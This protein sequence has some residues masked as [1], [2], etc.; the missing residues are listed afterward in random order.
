MKAK[1]SLRASGSV[2][3]TAVPL[4]STP[5]PSPCTRGSSAIAAHR[6]DRRSGGAQ[7]FDGSLRRTRRRPLDLPPLRA[8]D[9]AAI[10][11]ETAAGGPPTQVV[12][13]FAGGAGDR[14]H[15]LGGLGERHVQQCGELAAGADRCLNDTFQELATRPNLR[16]Y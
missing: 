12:D 14:H 7:L 6:F 4:I 13:R 11:V 1:S 15:V 10:G 5:C 16:L 2:S 8:N 3:L 9:T